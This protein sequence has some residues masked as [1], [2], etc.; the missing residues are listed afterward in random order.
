[1]A[2]IAGM[3]AVRE[4]LQAGR[5]LERVHVLAQAKP[6]GRLR[7]ILDSCRRAGVPVRQ[8]S[9]EQLD[10]LAAGAVHQGVV[11]VV[12]AY[13][14]TDLE[15][16]LEQMEAA[17]AK[18]P[19]LL[20]ALDGI[21]DPHNLGAII[22]SAHA[23]GADAVLI[24][25]RRAA[26]LTAAAAKAA[27][28]ALE[29]LPVARVTNV[30]RALEELKRRGFWITGLDERGEKSIFELDLSGPTVLVLGGEGHGL[31]EHVREKCD[32]LARIPVAGRVGTLNVSVA[33]GI[34]LFEALRQ[35]RGAPSVPRP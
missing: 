32:Y 24:P 4:A 22:R 26:G 14:Y 31:H 11:A 13:G 16:V 3:H 15:T 18:H 17:G 6:G 1:M 2:V 8:E 27:A 20:V 35:R 7:E 19:G 29:Y 25:E 33:A 12:A 34:A 21:E 10:R 30:G 5:Q 28:G 9:R 23:A